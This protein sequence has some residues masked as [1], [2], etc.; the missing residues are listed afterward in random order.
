MPLCASGPLG[1]ARLLQV[2]LRAALHAAGV[3]GWL[4]RGL[5]SNVKQVIVISSKVLELFRVYDVWQIL[6][7]FKRRFIK[8]CKRVTSLTTVGFR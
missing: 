3:Q 6:E 8:Y 1:T 5:P 7:G 2:R 4:H